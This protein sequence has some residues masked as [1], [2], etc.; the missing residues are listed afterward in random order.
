MCNTLTHI[1]LPPIHIHVQH[2]YIGHSPTN[3]RVFINADEFNTQTVFCCLYKTGN[4]V[5]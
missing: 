2:Q 3:G 1:F 4:H 5:F